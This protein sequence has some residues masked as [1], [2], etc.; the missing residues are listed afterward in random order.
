MPARAGV[1][2]RCELDA[3]RV[4][5]G[6]RSA[7]DAD[8]AGLHRLAEHL[9][10]VAAEL[11]D[12]VE[13]QDP[14][15]REG[16]FPRPRQRA[17]PGEPAMDVLLVAASTA[18]QRL[19]P[20][21]FVAARTFSLRQGQKIDYDGIAGS[22]DFDEYGNAITYLKVVQIEDG[23]LKRIGTLTD[24]EIASIVAEVLKLRK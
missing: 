11:G 19:A 16:D 13:E 4:G 21:S 5:A 6:A 12:L 20:P 3:G 17:A 14:V 8:G 24:K 2:G 1:R 15:V 23:K 18:L 22:Q 9:Q 10:D 7:G